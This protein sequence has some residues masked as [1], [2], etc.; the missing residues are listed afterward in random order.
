MAVSKATD[1]IANSESLK[2]ARTMDTEGVR[3]IGVLTQMD[4]VDENVDIIKD[5]N[6]LATP[7][8]LGYVGVY[9][10]PSKLTGELTLSQQYKEEEEFFKKHL[11]YQKYT[12]EIGAKFLI[13][14]LNTNFI[15][16]I[17]KTLPSIRE[18]ILSTLELK[19]EELSSYGD[20]E[21]ITDKK[22][23]GIFLLDSLERFVRSY[24]ELIEGKCI[25]NLDELVG[26]A[27]V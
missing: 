3:T 8:K 18:Q 12:G 2:L 21:S 25:D 15:K 1:D 13:K 9:L 17:K 23:Q 10:R 7:L 19:K 11:I 4:L 26:G 14:T 6:K 24:G 27:R 20:Y 16:H 22:D 5:F